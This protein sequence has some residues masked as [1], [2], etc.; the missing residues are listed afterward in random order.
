MDSNRFFGKI[1]T[2]TITVS[3]VNKLGCIHTV[4]L[5]RLAVE[6]ELITTNSPLKVS[7]KLPRYRARAGHGVSVDSTV[8]AFYILEPGS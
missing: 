4:F 8:L 1:A 2:Q 3:H 6:Q 5:V 7:L